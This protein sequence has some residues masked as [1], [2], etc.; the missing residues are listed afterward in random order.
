LLLVDTVTFH[1]ALGC[2]GF[3]IATQDAVVQQGFMMIMDLIMLGMDDVKGICK[4]ICDKLTPVLIPF[5]Q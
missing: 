2:I 1:T 3:T 5:M 4:I